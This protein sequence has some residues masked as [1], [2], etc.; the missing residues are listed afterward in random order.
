MKSESRMYYVKLAPG[1]LHRLRK[2]KGL[3]QK[4]LGQ[5]VGVAAGTICNWERSLCTCSERYI[6]ALAQALDCTVDELSDGAESM[7]VLR[8]V[9]V[10]GIK[11]APLPKANS[12]DQY[13]KA[14]GLTVKELAQRMQVSANTINLWENGKVIP[15]APKALLLAKTLGCTVS[16]LKI[17]GVF[18]F[19]FTNFAYNLQ[20]LR[21]ERGLSRAELSF[22]IFGN[23]RTAGLAALERG[24]YSPNFAQITQ[25]M[26]ALNCTLDDLQLAPDAPAAQKW[27]KTQ[28]AVQSKLRR[29][30]LERGLSQAKLAQALGVYGTYISLWE[31]GAGRP[32]AASMQKLC[33]FFGCTPEDLF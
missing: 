5:K 2:Q 19:D 32:N 20:R 4:E 11:P 16:D 28:S 12:I 17:P 3:T 31:I 15:S 8:R 21:C 22:A 6:K 7:T 24:K 25:I 30:R 29:K 33:D 26:Q 10:S 27:I 18:D 23:P 1:L 14:C 9:N 13:R